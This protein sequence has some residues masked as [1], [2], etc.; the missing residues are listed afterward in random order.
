MNI[1]SD[2]KTALV[3][4]RLN[5]IVCFASIVFGKKRIRIV[6]VLEEVIK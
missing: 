4:M 3:T 1:S 5:L 2:V 6:H